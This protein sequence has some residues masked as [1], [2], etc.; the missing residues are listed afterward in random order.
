MGIVFGVV[1]DN[2]FLQ[3]CAAGNVDAVRTS[4]SGVCSGIN[5]NKIDPILKGNA[6]HIAAIGQNKS[7]PQE[8]YAEILRLL[9]D[10]K[11]DLS[12]EHQESKGAPLHYAINGNNVQAVK[13]LL[14][15]RANPDQYHPNG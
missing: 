9:I 8:N 7:V 2:T 11:G 12:I 10:A 4:L 6:L 1:N 13:I 14:E 5:V 3:Y 15:S